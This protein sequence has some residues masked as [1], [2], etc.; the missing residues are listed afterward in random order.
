MSISAGALV[1]G[2]H[3]ATKGTVVASVGNLIYSPRV[4]RSGPETL[5]KCTLLGPLLRAINGLQSPSWPP[6]GAAKNLVW[7]PEASPGRS[8]R[9]PGSLRE[10]GRRPRA[11]QR[12]PGSDVGASGGRFSTLRSFIFDRFW[13]LL[14]L[15]FRQ[16]L[17]RARRRIPRAPLH[18]AR[19][20]ASRARLPPSCA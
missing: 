20:L 15:Q 3:Q 16:L 11:A 5:T 10:G 4:P 2:C 7:L 8:G 18:P 19:V 12:A 9:P 14:G 6:R 13:D 17:C 1:R